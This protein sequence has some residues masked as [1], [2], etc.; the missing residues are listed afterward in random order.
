MNDIS[1]QDTHVI[2]SNMFNNN[3]KQTAHFWNFN[4]VTKMQNS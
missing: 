2:D 3:K 1:K 4:I